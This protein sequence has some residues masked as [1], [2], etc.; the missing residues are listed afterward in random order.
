[1]KWWAIIGDKMKASLAD[2]ANILIL[3]YKYI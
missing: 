3:T 2:V 1:M